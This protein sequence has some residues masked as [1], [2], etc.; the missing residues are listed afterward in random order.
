[1]CIINDF[2]HIRFP[3]L[4]LEQ[5]PL[6]H[7]GHRSPGC[8]ESYNLLQSPLLIQQ[9]RLDYLPMMSVAAK[10]YMVFERTYDRRRCCSI[11]LFKTLAA[12]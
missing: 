6:R 11:E 9:P 1:M 4:N 8:E 5:E 3:D 2:Q 7:S 10:L 12:L